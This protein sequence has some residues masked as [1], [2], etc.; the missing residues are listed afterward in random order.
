ME[1]MK[2]IRERLRMAEE[3]NAVY[4]EEKFELEVH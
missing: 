1:D 2:D 4:I 3:A